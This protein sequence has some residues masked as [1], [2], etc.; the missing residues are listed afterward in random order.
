MLIVGVVWFGVNNMVYF[1]P[2]SI[3]NIILYT[4]KLHLSLLFICK[5]YIH[6]SYI[7]KIHHIIRLLSRH[8]KNKL[9]ILVINSK[10]NYFHF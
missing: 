10:C 8:I 5:S 4:L 7:L 2:F 9:R 6:I 3:F 1:I